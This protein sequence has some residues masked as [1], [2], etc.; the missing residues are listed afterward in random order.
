MPLDARLKPRPAVRDERLLRFAPAA[1]LR[2]ERLPALTKRFAGP[3]AVVGT[4]A[5][6]E[7]GQQGRPRAAP[8]A[9][10][11]SAAPAA[12]GAPALAP[13]PPPPPP[14][15]APAGRLAVMRHSVR[16]DNEPGA[17]WPDAAARPFDSPISD[18]ALPVAQAV[19][20]RAAAGV[21]RVRTSPM[22]RCVQTAALVASALG[23]A[24]L[25]VDLALGEM[26]PK[27][28]QALE[29]AAVPDAVARAWAP[30][31]VVELQRTAD[32]AIAAV[33]AAGGAP[34]AVR[35]A[36]VVRGQ[37][38]PFDEDHQGSVRRFREAIGAAQRDVAAADAAAGDLLL[39]TH[40]DAVNAV[41][42]LLPG[43]VELID[44]NEC[45][46]ALLDRAGAL[47]AHNRMQVLDMGAFG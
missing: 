20:L 44:V 13:P 21:R 34:G 29:A 41:K 7:R 14:S 6:S 19:E 5:W 3:A 32:E 43:E 23:V 33:G 40:G 28:R 15:L 9:A 16:V 35:V 25:E 17:T 8:P 1:A 18:L 30:L 4:V 11:A 22:R 42:Y 47:A 31:S 38:P 12:A 10:A 24:E 26:M 36:A 46:W 45:A 39:V 37:L 27:V 2:D